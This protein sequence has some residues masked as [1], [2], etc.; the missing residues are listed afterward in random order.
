[1]AFVL[2]FSPRKSYAKEK[3]FYGIEDECDK[4]IL[5]QSAFAY[6]VCEGIDKKRAC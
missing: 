4:P 2:C 3:I 6:L 1:M 5:T